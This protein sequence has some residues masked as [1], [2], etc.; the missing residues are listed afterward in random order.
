MR[1]V[2]VLANQLDGTNTLFQD[3]LANTTDGEWTARVWPE[4]NTLGFTA[5]HL[6]RTSDFAIQTCVRSVPEVGHDPVAGV[7]IGLTLEEADQVA[8]QHSKTEVAA[9][10]KAVHAEIRSWLTGR[11]EA[12]LEAVPD[13][14]PNARRFP[15][16]L[17]PKHADALAWDGFPTWRFIAGPCV[18]HWRGHF[19]EMELLRQVLRMG[20]GE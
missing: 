17:E 6:V 19:G 13:W 3:L 9:Y 5:W 12:D 8:R 4:T 15:A 10:A 14:R 20:A 2:D 1:A 16:Y 11:T 7:G 18:G